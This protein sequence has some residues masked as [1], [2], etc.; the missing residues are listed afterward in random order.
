[1]VSFQQ[2][3]ALCQESPWLSLQ[4]D[5]IDASGSVQAPRCESLGIPRLLSRAQQLL[6]I[7]EL[8]RKVLQGCTVSAFGGFRVRF[9]CLQSH[10]DFIDSLRPGPGH[11]VML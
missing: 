10:N 2:P 7:M 4:S 11:Q 9:E 3:S 1:M 8:S 5:Q 6:Q